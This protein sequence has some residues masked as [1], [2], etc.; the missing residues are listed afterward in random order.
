MEKQEKYWRFCAVGNI[1]AQHTDEEGNIYYGTKAYVGGTKVYID[2]RTLLLNPGMITV[3]GLNRYKRYSIES[4]P[5][6][7]IENVRLKQVF[8][9]TILEIMDY[10]E[11]MDG[12]PWRG[13]TAQDKKEIL[14]FVEKWHNMLLEG[15][16]V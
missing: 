13:R 3:I 1:K 4:V 10:L 14:S 16:E 11:H 2:D 9:P 5:I 15:K 12:W 6:S 7:L 8:K